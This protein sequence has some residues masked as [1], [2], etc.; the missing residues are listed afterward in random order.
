MTMLPSP[1]PDKPG[2]AM[3]VD[4]LAAA[5]RYHNHRYFELA[6]PVIDDYAFDAL[7]QRLQAL[8]PD[9]PALS[10]LTPV[11][12]GAGDKVAHDE[13]MLSLDKCYDGETLARWA[14]TFEGK[15]IESPK[16]DGVAASLKYGAD[17]RLAL[18]VTRGDGRRGEAF[19]ANARH[20]ED[21]PTRIADG[22]VEVRGE[23]YLRLSVFRSLAGDFSNPRNTAAG[24]IKQKDPGRTA[25]YRLTFFLYDVVGRDFETETDKRDWAGAQGFAVAEARAIDR[26]EMQAGYERW[27]A[28]RGELD[29]EIDGVV[30]RADRVSEQRRLGLTAHHPRYAIAYKFQGD[31]GRSTLVDVVW[32]VSRTGVITPVAII[33]PIELSGA[34]VTRCSLHNLAILRKLDVSLGATVVAVRRGGVI[35]H[36]EAVIEPGERPV[37]P[38]SACPSCGSETVEDGDVLTCSR[39]ADCPDVRLGTLQHFCKAAEI[40]GFGPKVVAQLIE[41]GLVRTPADLYDLDPAALMGLDR[42]GERSARKLV[43]SVQARRRLPLATFLR[44]LGVDD[45]GDVVSELLAGECRT[46]DGCLAATEDQLTAVHGIGPITARA[47]T[48]GLARRADLVAA[49]RDRIAIDEHLPSTASAGA[50]SAADPIAGRSFVFTGR[51][52]TLSRKEAQQLVRRRGGTTPAGVARDLDVLVVGDDAS[53]LADAGDKSGK[54]RAAEHLVADGA[55][56]RIISESA[57]LDMVGAEPDAAGPGA[58]PAAVAAPESDAEHGRGTAQE[59]AADQIRLL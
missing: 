55:P 27:L 20:I 8:A 41:R 33:D 32:S 44:A 17:G 16:I 13:P 31:S 4:E 49:L 48:A 52:A 58:A 29:Y 43:A 14:A 50:T 47:I 42:M 26:A 28:R 51:L 10:E 34:L 57:F 30:Y 46:L 45:L 24:A 18:A 25:D 36:I 2:D 39:P 35:P 15:V 23:V 6:D 3:T 5:V 53:A 56:I 40:D 21:L 7:A 1:P 59:P 37:T 12:G 54:H 11:V 9:H 38:P 22:P 19:T